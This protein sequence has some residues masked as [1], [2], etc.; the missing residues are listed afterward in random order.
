MSTLSVV[1]PSSPLLPTI[2][3]P[4]MTAEE[5]FQKYEHQ[6]V[7]LI[8][9]IVKEL[10]MPTLKHGY[11]C[12]EIAAILR[13]HVKKNDLGRVMSNDSFVKVRR[14]PDSIRG[15]DVCYISY[16]RL[17]K[18]EIPEGLLD[19]VPDLVIEVRSPSD[20]WTEMI[21]KVLD[22]LS[23]GVRVIVVLNPPTKSVAVYRPDTEGDIFRREQEL[24]V[25]DILPGFSVEVRKL[26]E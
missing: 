11:I 22:Y 6:Q 16:E 12:S 15:A 21:A 8:E 25:P 14:N 10:P 4:L 20:T 24:V 7:E 5:F 23:A 13:E 26:F 1:S 19:V 18:G 2:T 17:P 9:G 3:Q